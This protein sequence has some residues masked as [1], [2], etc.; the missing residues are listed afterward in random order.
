MFAE[1]LEIAEKIRALKE[2]GEDEGWKATPNDF[3][4]C[5]DFKNMCDRDVAKNSRLMN[6]PKD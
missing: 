6:A 3:C 2:A 1:V 4:W 5:C